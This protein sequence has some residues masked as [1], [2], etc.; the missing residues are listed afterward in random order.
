MVGGENHPTFL[1]DVLEAPDPDSERSEAKEPAE[2]SSDKTRP[3]VGPS[4][5]GNDRFRFHQVLRQ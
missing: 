4:F 2:Q 5:S 1:R 3:P